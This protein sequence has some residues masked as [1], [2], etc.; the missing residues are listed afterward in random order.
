[1]IRTACL[2]LIA[3]PAFAAVVSATPTDVVIEHSVET[4]RSRVELFQLVIHPEKWWS[5]DHTYSHDAKNLS[6]E[7]KPGGCYCEN[8]S[9]GAVAHGSVLQ[10]RSGEVLRLQTAL[11]PLQVKAVVG[12]LDFVLKDVGA[13]ARLTVTYRVSGGPGQAL[14]KLAGPVDIVLGEQVARLQRLAESGSPEKLK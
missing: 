7:L 3:M 10:W 5:S 14:D 11:G 13:K 6:L 8:W 4:A 12:V 9:G 2:L 1:M